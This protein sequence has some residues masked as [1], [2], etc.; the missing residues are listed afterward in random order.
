MGASFT[1]YVTMGG[2]SQSRLWCQIV[3]DICGVPVLRSTTTEATCL[4]AGILAAAAAGWFSDAASA[5][6][7][8]TDTSDRF[9]PEP[10]MQ[11][12]YE[13]LYNEVYKTLFPTVQPLVDRLTGLT[14]NL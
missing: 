3:A 14:H 13:P 7:A 6:E 9:T 10:E 4:G 11:A 8:M 12:R 2:G 5:A 1:E